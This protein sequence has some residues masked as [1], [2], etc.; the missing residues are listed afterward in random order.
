MERAIHT[1]LN[2]NSPNN[3]SFS[4]PHHPTPDPPK[5]SEPHHAMRPNGLRALDHDPTSD[6]STFGAHKYFNHG[7]NNDNI[8]RVTINGNSRVSPLLNLDTEHKHSPE[9]G[10]ITKSTRSSFSNSASSSVGGNG[11]YNNMIN[12]YKAHSFHVATPTPP[13]SSSKSTLNNKAGLL[14]HHPQKNTISVINPPQTSSNLTKKLRTSSNLTKKLR[15]SLSKSIWLLR[16]KCPCS[17]K[18][19]VQ[20]KGNTKNYSP[21]PKTSPSQTQTLTHNQIYKDSLNHKAAAPPSSSNKELKS[22]SLFHHHHPPAMNQARRPPSEGGF[23]FPLVMA[24]NS[25]KPTNPHQVLLNVVHEEEDTTPRESLHVFQPPSPSKSR[26]MDD[27]AASD[28]SSDLFE[29]ESFSTQT[30]TLPYPITTPSIALCHETTDHE[31]FFTADAGCSLWRR[32]R[33]RDTEVLPPL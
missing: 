27:D 18:K 2:P 31:F 19:S 7:T 32:R 11:N 1:N 25:T 29:I 33:L 6:L 17:D 20:V 15:T 9:Q 22:Q 21:K 4:S 13:P 5:K 8:Q 23:A 12:N 14:F 24:T 30:T 28:A 10:D 16:R 3:V 26:A